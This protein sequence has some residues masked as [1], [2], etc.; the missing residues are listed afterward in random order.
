[1]NCLLNKTMARFVVAKGLMSA[2]EIVKRRQEDRLVANFLTQRES[3]AA[4]VQCVLFLTYS[5][6]EIAVF[7]QCY[8]LSTA[9]ADDFIELLS[10]PVLFRRLLTTSLRCVDYSDLTKC[11]CFVTPFFPGAAQRETTLIVRKRLLVI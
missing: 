11:I 9:V 5:E 7:V 1:M 3:F 10:S 8:C 2:R 6:E 4:G